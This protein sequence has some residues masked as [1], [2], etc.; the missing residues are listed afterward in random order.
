MA[1]PHVLVKCDAE[2]YRK[3]LVVEKFGDICAAEVMVKEVKALVVDFYLSPGV[4]YGDLK[5]FF[6]VNLLMYNLKTIK[7]YK[8]LQRREYDDIPMLIS[9]GFESG[10]EFR[11]RLRFRGVHEAYI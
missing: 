1:T 4:T 9:G 5:D 6:E 10:F 3:A 8:S 7:I 11:K 2:V